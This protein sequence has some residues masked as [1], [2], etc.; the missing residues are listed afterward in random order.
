LQ[1]ND[2]YWGSPTV[3][4]SLNSVIEVNIFDFDADIYSQQLTVF[5]KTKLRDEVK[6]NGL[7]ELKKQLAKDKEDSLAVL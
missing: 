1:R 3:G 5:I 6:F 2:E 4:G 7:E